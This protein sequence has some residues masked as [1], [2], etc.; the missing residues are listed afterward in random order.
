[1]PSC[2]I[3]FMDVRQERRPVMTRTARRDT[4]RG[5]EPS[6][7]EQGWLPV[8]PFRRALGNRAAVLLEFE[9]RGLLCAR[10]RDPLFAAKL[11][12]IAPQVALAVDLDEV[13]A[14]HDLSPP[15]RQDGDRQ[16]SPGHGKRSPRPRW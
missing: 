12:H 9:K 14:G 16:R 2:C 4:P 11:E 10:L 1:M 6:R 3:T 7:G 13:E 5:Q 15:V 8:A